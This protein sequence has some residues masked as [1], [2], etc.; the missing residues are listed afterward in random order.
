MAEI[1]I[2]LK[3]IR[4][5]SPCGS[6]WKKVYTANNGDMNKPFPVKSIIDSNDLDDCLWALRCLPEHDKLWRIYAVWCARQVQHLMI[7]QRSIAALDAAEDFANGTINTEQ[8]AAAREA[9]REAAAA[10]AAEAAAAAAREAARE[11]VWEAAREA[12][13]EA[14]REA[15][16]EKLIKILIAGK[17]V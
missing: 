12:A 14:V 3:Q 16:K 5:N 7:D 13:R 1:M 11:A 17:F 10:A 4:D 6:G 9:A 2:T 15:Q 8:L